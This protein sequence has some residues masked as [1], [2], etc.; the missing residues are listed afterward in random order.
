M[1]RP[2]ALTVINQQVIGTALANSTTRTNLLPTNARYILAPNWDISFGTQMHIRAGGR[3]SNIVTAPGTLTLDIGFGSV[4]VF[5]MGAMAL[6]IVAKTDVTWDLDLIL[7][8]SVFATGVNS[9]MY[10]R[11]KWTSESVIGSPLVSVGGSGVFNLPV[12]SPTDGTSFDNSLTTNDVGL[13]ATWQ[14]ANSGNSIRCDDF[15]LTLEN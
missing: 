2:Y 6:N 9:K 13:Y 3:I 14:T 10:G 12:T 11:G 1:P 7:K 8:C 4:V 5:N 15:R